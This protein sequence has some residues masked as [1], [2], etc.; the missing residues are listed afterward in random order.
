MWRIGTLL[1]TALLFFVLGYVVRDKHPNISSSIES[2]F[3]SQTKN[4]PLP[5]NELTIPS[6]INR[7]YYSSD[8]QVEKV[9]GEFDEYTAY[10]FSY[11]SL[12][13]KVTGQLNVPHSVRDA[14]TNQTPIIVMMRG[15]VPASIYQTGIGTRNAAAVFA[16]EGYI[17]L[18]PDF[19]G[20]GGSDPQPEN[21]WQARFERP[22]NVVE[23][24]KSIR[25]EGVP[26]PKQ[27]SETTTDLP[28][29]RS[30][31]PSSLG[32]WGHSNGGQIAISVLEILGEPIPTTLWA[33]VLA[34]F[35]YSVLFFTD[36]EDDEGKVSRKDLALFEED[37]DV[38]GFSVTQH[39]GRLRGPIQ[40]HHGTAD[41]A[42]LKVWSDE[43][44][45]RIKAENERRETLKKSQEA[46]IATSSS[47]RTDALINEHSDFSEEIELTYFVYQGANHDMVPS[48]DTVVQRDVEF[49]NR[50]LR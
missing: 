23:L 45:A 3:V 14:T 27:T 35:P 36:E 29:K 8:L 7:E 47:E 49:F 30:V 17:T 34:P 43:F 50:E 26:I 38:F 2:P 39:L 4:S 22:I 32:F 42:A 10:L 19:L 11:R 28:I 12:D 48:W 15:Y 16:R 5:L 31:T 46:L 20:S 25:E 41:E 33:P 24:V 6:L 40:L 44:T 13:K 18:A 9:L 21:H 37:Y 1:L